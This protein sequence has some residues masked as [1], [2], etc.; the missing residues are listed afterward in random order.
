MPVCLHCFGYFWH[1]GCMNAPNIYISNDAKLMTRSSLHV[2]DDGELTNVRL[3]ETF[4]MLNDFLPQ[5]HYHLTEYRK[6]TRMAVV[7]APSFMFHPYVK[8]PD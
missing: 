2:R 5:C 6:L 1:V 4:A 3:V 8:L 7:G